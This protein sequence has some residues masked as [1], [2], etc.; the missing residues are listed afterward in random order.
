M[1]PQT[2]E[3]NEEIEGI[4]AEIAKHLDETTLAPLWSEGERLTLKEAIALARAT[5]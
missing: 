2:D 4:R 1:R 5:H 3:D